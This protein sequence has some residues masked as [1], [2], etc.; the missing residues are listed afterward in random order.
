MRRA[1]WLVQFEKWYPENDGSG[2][3]RRLSMSS[4]TS[5]SWAI[6]LVKMMVKRRVK[7]DDAP[8]ST[9]SLTV[10]RTGTGIFAIDA[11]LN[12]IYKL[13]AA[14]LFVANVLALKAPTERN[15]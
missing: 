4:A 7:D 9:A 6:G 11:R 15:D 2:V 13:Q 1:E 8:R 3:D 10:A 12:C 14:V 5:I